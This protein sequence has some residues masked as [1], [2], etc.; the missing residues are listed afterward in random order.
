MYNFILCSK[1]ALNYFFGCFI[2][3]LSNNILFPLYIQQIYREDNDDEE[4]KTISYGE[5]VVLFGFSFVWR[6][7]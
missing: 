3:Y 5:N 6:V 7:A 4:T 2:A 1:H